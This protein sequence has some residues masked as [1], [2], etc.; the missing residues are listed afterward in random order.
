MTFDEE[1]K[2]AFAK[3]FTEYL[4]ASGKSAADISRLLDVDR[5]SVSWWKTGR[6][7]PTIERIRQLAN[8]F[9][10]N[11]SD[12]LSSDATTPDLI[13]SGDEKE[14]IIEYR[15][16]DDTTKAMIDRL[17]T[18]NKHLKGVLQSSKTPTDTE[19]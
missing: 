9:N 1:N 10:C 11:V 7:T 2:Q 4:E 5:S 8:I 17:L 18:Y 14:L 13:L 3:K 6:S 12:L 19:Q 15:K 16:S